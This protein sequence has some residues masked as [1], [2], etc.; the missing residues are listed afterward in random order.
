MKTHTRQ[1]RFTARRRANY[2]SLFTISRNFQLRSV[3]QQRSRKERLYSEKAKK[4]GRAHTDKARAKERRCIAVKSLHRRGEQMLP[5]LLLARA[6][7]CKHKT[8]APSGGRGCAGRKGARERRAFAYVLACSAPIYYRGRGGKKN[9][10]AHP[11]VHYPAIKR[12][13]VYYPSIVIFSLFYYIQ[14]FM[15]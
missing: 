5:L 10:H 13:A 1:N 12:P 14:S 4:H 3:T 2:G 9:V 11:A 6:R 15:V 7:V 8:R